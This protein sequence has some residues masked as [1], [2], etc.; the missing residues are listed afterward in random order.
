[1]AQMSAD[2]QAAALKAQERAA[3]SRSIGNFFGGLIFSG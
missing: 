1:M 2:A 3:N